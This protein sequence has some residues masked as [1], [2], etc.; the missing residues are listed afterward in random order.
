MNFCLF[1]KVC[2]RFKAEKLS[3]IDTVFF[4]SDEQ[5]Y[6]KESRVDKDAEKVSFESIV[7]TT[8]PN[9]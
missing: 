4:E 3:I 8:K 5:M 7:E 1:V 2:E 9:E 6:Y